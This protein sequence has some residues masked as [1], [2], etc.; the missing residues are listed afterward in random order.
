MNRLSGNGTRTDSPKLVVSRRCVLL[1]WRIMSLGAEF[2]APG[3]D[4]QTVEEAQEEFKA[5]VEP[6]L[7]SM[8]RRGY[9]APAVRRVH[10]PKPGKRVRLACHVWPKRSVAQVLSAIYSCPARSAKVPITPSHA[11][12]SDSGAEG[13]L[14]P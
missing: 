3:V 7:R 5:W 10:I 6:M 11:H 12:G 4:G 14:G 13:E 8:H 2:A 1:H 9:P